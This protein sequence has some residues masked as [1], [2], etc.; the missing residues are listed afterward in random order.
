MRLVVG[1]LREDAPA[2]A[3]RFGD[4]TDVTPLRNASTGPVTPERAG[5]YVAKEPGYP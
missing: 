1:P 4:Q 5:A 2:L 3:P